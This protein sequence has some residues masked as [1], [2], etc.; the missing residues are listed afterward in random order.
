MGDVPKI[1]D[2]VNDLAQ[3]PASNEPVI[4]REHLVM[5]WP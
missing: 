4:S 3:D 5:I 2:N 1:D